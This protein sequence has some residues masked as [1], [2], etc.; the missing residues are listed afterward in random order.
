MYS[1]FT[2]R[3][4]KFSFTC[5]IY[6]IIGFYFDNFKFINKIQFYD[7]EKLV[8]NIKFAQYWSEILNFFMHTHL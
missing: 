6:G 4:L 8:S 5:Y 2:H 1:W 7:S 3:L